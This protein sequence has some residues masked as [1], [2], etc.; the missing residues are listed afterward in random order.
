MKKN[1]PF[2]SAEYGDHNQHHDASSDWVAGDAGLSVLTARTTPSEDRGL[3][4]RWVIPLKFLCH[5]ACITHPG[6]IT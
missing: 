4:T 1:S 5:L 3:S 6:W 2:P